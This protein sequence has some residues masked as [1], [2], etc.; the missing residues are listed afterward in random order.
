MDA[1]Q[2]PAAFLPHDVSGNL[3]Y[4]TTSTTPP[5]NGRVPNQGLEGLTV[6]ADN[7]KLYALM[8]S[9]LIQVRDPA[10]RAA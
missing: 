1:F 9:A 8:Q 4:T 5:A 10:Y 3:Y 6:S 7:T 2:P